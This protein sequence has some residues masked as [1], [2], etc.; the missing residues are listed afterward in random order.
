MI[1]TI[2]TDARLTMIAIAALLAYAVSLYRWPWRPCWW[3]EGTGL[4][5]SSNKRRHGTCWRC[6]G[7][8]HVQRLGA[9][10]VH[11]LAW[12]IRGEWSRSR[13]RRAEERAKRRSMHPRDLADR[14]N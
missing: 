7:N 6:H 8:K 4:S 10:T 5:R 2:E 14:D 11:R 13:A 9:R 12:A 1:H 3:C